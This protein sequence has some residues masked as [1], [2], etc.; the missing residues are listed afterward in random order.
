MQK[1]WLADLLIIFANFDHKQT[2]KQEL[3]MSCIIW[4]LKY[5]R[6]WSLRSCILTPTFIYDNG[7]LTDIKNTY[8][9]V[10]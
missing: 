6:V 10:L 8:T 7:T 3:C 5:V 2:N 4:I 1:P 9:P